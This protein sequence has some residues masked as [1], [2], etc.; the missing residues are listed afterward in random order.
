MSAELVAKPIRED[1]FEAWWRR[2]GELVEAPNARRG[3][4]SGVVRI[5]DAQHGLLYVKRQVGHLCYDLFHLLGRPTALRE[6]DALTAFPKIGITVPELVY[7][8]ARR[9]SGWRTV[10]VTKALAG[11]EDIRKWYDAGG[12]DRLGSE[13]HDR[14]LRKIGAT[15]ATMHRHRWQHTCLHAKHLFI[16]TAP[17]DDGL[18]A[19]AL[20]DLEK[21]RRNLFASTA[22][23]RDLRQLRR[24]SPMWNDRDFALMLEGH[25]ETFGKQVM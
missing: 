11:Y 7:C 24:H 4:E 17:A 5:R 9:K 21:A 1:P 10:L 15:L 16:S 14:L 23:R 8:E 22:A 18:P 6:R 13:M 2:E 25:R 19:I 3:G 20:L 12:R